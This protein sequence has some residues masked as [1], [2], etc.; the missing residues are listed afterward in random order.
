MKLIRLLCLGAYILPATAGTT[1]W[2]NDSL[3]Y[4]HTE[5]LI[6]GKKYREALERL[7]DIDSPLSTVNNYTVSLLGLKAEA[8]EQLGDIR[9]AYRFLSYHSYYYDTYHKERHQQFADSLEKTTERVSL[10]NNLM[11]NEMKIKQGKERLL[12]TNTY[13]ALIGIGAMLL[14]TLLFALWKQSLRQK[15]KKQEELD[16]L[17]QQQRLTQLELQLEAALKERKNIAQRL[18]NEVFP[19][20]DHIRENISQD[21]ITHTDIEG[22]QQLLQQSQQEMANMVRDTLPDLQ[23][24]VMLS[25]TVKELLQFIPPQLLQ[26]DFQLIGEEQSIDEQHAYQLL[27]IIQE[28]IQNVLKHSKASLLN[29][30]L[31]YS[32]KQVSINISGNARA[33]KSKI[34]ATQSGI[35]KLN[36]ENRAIAI[37]AHFCFSDQ[38]NTLDLTYPF[39]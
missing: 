5:T 1:S 4:Q 35:G 20:I 10:E 31:Q 34:I 14:F 11:T 12:A 6:R 38:D 21:E 30:T 36:I 29:I 2:S 16:Q 9:N 37:D 7:R 25:D 28:F 13:L 23:A 18:E 32:A 26:V 22:I 15:K 3:L 24:Q 33:A 19:L 39:R 8:F 27:R 17:E